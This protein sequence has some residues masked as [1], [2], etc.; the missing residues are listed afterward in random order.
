MVLVSLEYSSK[1]SESG[2]NASDYGSSAINTTE[3]SQKNNEMCLL[4]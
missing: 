4:Q 2:S 1:T 3:T